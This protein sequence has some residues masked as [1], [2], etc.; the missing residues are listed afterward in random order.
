MTVPIQVVHGKERKALR[1]LINIYGD[2]TTTV[3]NALHAMAARIA[4]ATGVSPEDFSAGMKH[5]WDFLAN[6]INDRDGMQ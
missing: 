5:H 1:A 2:D 6:S 3:L 4:I